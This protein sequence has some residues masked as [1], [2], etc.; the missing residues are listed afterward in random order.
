[1]YMHDSKQ[2]SFITQNL[3][4]FPPSKNWYASPST[5]KWSVNQGAS[6][7]QILIYIY[8]Y[9]Y[10]YVHT[11]F[12]LVNGSI[13]QILVFSSLYMSAFV[14]FRHLSS[15]YRSVF[16]NFWHFDYMHVSILNFGYFRIV[17]ILLKQDKYKED[18]SWWSILSTGFDHHCYIFR[19]CATDIS[20]VLSRRKTTISL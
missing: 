15:L 4:H 3:S 17:S 14:S 12:V 2:I 19:K 9:I 16:L 5:K 1:M 7:W 10:I 18:L 20:R 8:I 11:F 6:F 13:S